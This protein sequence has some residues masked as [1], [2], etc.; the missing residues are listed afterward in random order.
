M[1]FS[2]AIFGYN[3][4][5]AANTMKAC[6]CPQ[7]VSACRNDP[8][9]LIPADIQRISAFLHISAAA[10]LENYLVWIEKSARGRKYSALAPAKLRRDRFVVAPGGRATEKYAANKGRCLFLDEAERCQI[11]PVKPLECRA[12][13]GCSNTFLGRPYHKRVVEEYFRSRWQGY[14]T[15]QASRKLS[16]R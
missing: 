5:A 3:V 9:R 1:L 2:A 15:A 12:Y 7:C 6:T 10:L 4:L 14:I 13:M 8:G 11:H 16:R